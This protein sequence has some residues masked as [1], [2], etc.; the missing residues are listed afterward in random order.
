V[1]AHEFSKG[2]I[3]RRKRRK[4]ST[5][6][7]SMMNGLAELDPSVDRDSNRSLR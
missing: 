1:L 6:T 2:R 7:P 5:V 3:I 4:S